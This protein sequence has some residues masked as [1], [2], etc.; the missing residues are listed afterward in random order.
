MKNNYLPSERYYVYAH[1]C[2]FSGLFLYVGHGKKARAWIHGS[3]NTV[4]RS[5]EHLDWLDYLN[6]EGYLPCDYVYILEKNLT[7]TQA[8]IKEQK[9]IREQTPKFNKPLGKSL[10]K[11]N[12]E[13][14]TILQELRNLG[15]SYKKISEETGFSTMTV[16]RALN[17]KNR[18]KPNEK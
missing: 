2:P 14:F 17:N 9:Y 3:K 15:F 6:E 1:V 8:C 11:I 10:L 16:F 18:N 13:D 4:L 7:K 12:T 5:E